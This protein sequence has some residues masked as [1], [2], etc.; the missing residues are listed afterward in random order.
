MRTQVIVVLAALGSG[1][2]VHALPIGE[3]LIAGQATVSRT[4]TARLDIRQGSPNAILNW[5]AFSI[6]RGETVAVQQPGASSVLLNRVTG[7]QPSEILG[8]LTANG[9]VFLVNPGGILFAP[10]A[11]VSVGG[12]VAS[13]LDIS[14]DDLMAGRYR[15]AG[16]GS[17]A[18]VTNQG[19]LRAAERGTIGLLG[20]VVTNQGT[21]EARLGTVGLVA[22]NRVVLDFAGDGLTTLRVD[23]GV[24]RAAVRNEGMVIAD[25]GR[26]VLTA[27]AAGD[28][29]QS[30]VNQTGVVQARS[31][32]ERNGEIVLDAGEAG[33]TVQAGRLDVAG[34]EAGQV[35]GVA[36][37]LGESV[38][39][40]AGATIDARGAAGGGTVLV[41]GSLQGADRSI[42]HAARTTI[43]AGAALAT[44]ATDAGRGGTVVAWSDGHTRVQGTLSARG[45]PRGG[46]GGTVETSG[47]VLDVAGARVSAAAPQGRA[48]T[49]LLDPV[50]VDI[51]GPVVKPPA[52]PLVALAAAAD[53]VLPVPPAAARSI[54]PADTVNSALSEG[55]SVTIT[56]SGT[57]GNGDITL[58]GAYTDVPG[59]ISYGPAAIAYSGA[60]DATLTLRADR[61]VS[62]EPGTSI[63]AAGTGRLNV[64]LNSAAGGSGPGP[65]RIASREIRTNG[66]DLIVGSGPDP[67]VGAATGGTGADGVA[68][69]AGEGPRIVISTAR[70]GALG[71]VMSIRGAGGDSTTGGSGGDGV[72]IGSVDLTT[73]GGAVTITGTGGGSTSTLEPGTGGYG[74]V[75]ARATVDS[76]G[77]RIEATGTGGAGRAPGDGLFAFASDFMSGGGDVVMTGAGGAARFPVGEAV[78]R[79]A[80]VHLDGSAVDARNAAGGGTG[81]VS[82]TG[83]GSGG[84]A[85]EGGVEIVEGTIR[86]AAGGITI[87]GVGGGRAPGVRLDSLETGCGS[88]GTDACNVIETA[89]GPIDIRGLADPATGREGVVII[90][91][92]AVRASGA[93]QILVAG[94]AGAVAG[95]GVGA[96]AGVEVGPGSTITSGPGGSILVAG[97]GVRAGDH[98]VR[99]DD[100]ARVGGSASTSVD[101]VIGGSAGAGGRGVI[102][103]NG[104]GTAPT[105]VTAGMVNLRP[106]GVDASG[107]VVERSGGNIAISPNPVVPVEP[108]PPPEPGP[109][110]EGEFIEGSARF[111]ALAVRARPAAVRDPVAL[112]LTLRDLAAVGGTAR[113]LVIGSDLHGG[114]IDVNAPVTRDGNLTLQVGGAGGSIAVDNTISAPGSTVALVAGGSITQAAPILA[115][116][117]LATSSGGDVTL[118]NAANAVARASVSAPSGSVQFAN[119]SSTVL[120]P[121]EALGVAAAT[122]RPAAITLPPWQF[123][124][125]FLARTIAGDL[126]L[127]QGIARGGAG[128]GDID[129]VAGGG[130]LTGSRF[131][132]AGGHALDA[133]DGGVWRVWAPS[134][135]GEARGG[136]AGAGAYPNIYG[137][138]FGGSCA[139]SAFGAGNQFVYVR[140]PTVEVDVSPQT[141]AFGAPNPPLAYSVDGV[142]TVLGDTISSAVV[143]DSSTGAGFSSPAGVYPVN[144]NFRSPTGYNI[145][146]TRGTIGSFSRIDIPTTLTVIGGSPTIV[147]PGPN[148]P[149]FDSSTIYGRNLGGANACF[150]T[151]R[152]E[153]ALDGSQAGDF[154]ERDWLRVRLRPQMGNCMALGQDSGCAD[155]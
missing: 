133:G 41:G 131:R 50:D 124:R 55:T 16:N 2:H 47:R 128:A 75:L 81:S 148:D 137:C 57:G 38:D 17:T 7:G 139:A 143:V 19:T 65:I 27:R 145:V 51:V 147:P 102:L 11:S 37:V 63:A 22:A 40:A 155:F 89:T 138:Q 98:G 3:Q 61:G 21:I 105:I 59:Q 117:L 134:W 74:V 129:L 8:S 103:S 96:V 9:R 34:L 6:G 141:R 111:N 95:S 109:G 94:R 60:T 122:N 73:G 152:M 45:G 97:E 92:S 44:D 28:L 107:A 67:R 142:M 1:T 104:D 113:V 83:T 29:A 71:G 18:A 120:G 62:L 80:G 4:G 85:G 140:Q 23:E 114:A 36:R 91:P 144:A 13:T 108:A 78:A 20:G 118:A 58:R 127:E 126:A 25:G 110:T 151:G 70:S 153:M 150:A 31:L 121:V 82:I 100:S 154:L 24:V 132:N 88:T 84:D 10:G 99:I 123:A 146:S 115:G 49:W 46:D 76:A 72:A 5:G 54:V 64:V 79:G 15:F 32:V 12:L 101:V 130:V 119:A 30:V 106:L 14:N 136:L 43:A 69:G 68:I 48:G 33:Q 116:A 149:T 35:G 42:T 90:G 112:D 93:G 86:T 53:I 66:G 125:S 52:E 56:T 26:A 77:G 135:E 39:L 87:R